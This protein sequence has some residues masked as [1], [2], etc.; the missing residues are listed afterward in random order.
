MTHNLDKDYYVHRVVSGDTIS[1]LVEYYYGKN[2]TS[3]WDLV[4]DTNNLK[5]FEIFSDQILLFPKNIDLRT[6]FEQLG[7]SCK[8][9]ESKFENSISGYPYKYIRLDGRGFSKL[10]K[11]MEKPY[12]MYFSY[13]MNSLLNSLM[14][15]FDFHIGYVQSDEI[16]L[17]WL[18]KDDGST[19][20]LFNGRVQ[21][22]TSVIAGYASAEFNRIFS[23]CFVNLLAEKKVAT[24]DARVVGF[25]KFTELQDMFKWRYIDCKKNAVQTAAWVKFGHKETMNKSTHQKREM[26]K[27]AGYNFDELPS[28]YWEGTFMIKEKTL[29]NPAEFEHVPEKYRP[30]E[31]VERSEI[32]I[33]NIKDWLD[34]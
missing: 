6:E 10:T 19:N 14:K 11:D 31:P 34:E 1:E 9:L 22:L 21:K 26:L 27:D 17:A 30:T 15:E 5:S 8:Y 33:K 23:K 13:C 7:D 20:D 25:D 28:N 12:D 29:K 24:F 16:S 4:K 3:L 32:V 2:D 18:P